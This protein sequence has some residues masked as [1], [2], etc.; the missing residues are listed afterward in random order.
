MRIILLFIISLSFIACQ[1]NQNLDIIGSWTTTNVQDNTGMNITDKVDFNKD[2]SYV[3]TMYSNGDSLVSEMKG[4]YEIDKNKQTLIVTTSGAN[5]KHKI[6]D[7]DKDNLKIKTSQGVE[8]S[9]KRI[10]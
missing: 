4:S 3:L 7:F 5:F 1:S 8:M 2:G 10:K 9:M 6:I